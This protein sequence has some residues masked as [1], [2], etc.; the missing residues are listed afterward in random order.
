[1]P[2]IRNKNLQ[3]RRM[4]SALQGVGQSDLESGLS[5]Y[6]P[7]ASQPTQS[8]NYV[9]DILNFGTSL[10]NYK[11]Q[12]SQPQTEVRYMQAPQSSMFGG[13]STPMLLAAGLAA[14]FILTMK[15]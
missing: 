11:S 8:P 15:K 12:S 9:T 13:I 5:T 2:A 10:L 14:V 6:N 4:G 7:Y 3:S 1:M